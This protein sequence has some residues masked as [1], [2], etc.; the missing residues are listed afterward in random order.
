MPDLTLSDFAER[1]EDVMSTVM[2]GFA[3]MQTNELFKGEITLPQFFILSHLDKHGESKMN[4]LAKFMDVTTAAA[5][6]IVDRLV[7]CGYAARVYDP[8]DRRVINIR[9]TRKGSN[10]VKRIGRQRREVT[11]EVFGRISKEERENYLAIMLHIRDVLT[12]DRKN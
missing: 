11:S 3:K 8:K 4:E 1:I 6:G 7:R 5:T 9:L 12:E 2:K 10:L